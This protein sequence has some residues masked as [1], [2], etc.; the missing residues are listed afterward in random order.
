MPTLSGHREPAPVRVHQKPVQ[1]RPDA[2]IDPY[3]GFELSRLDFPLDDLASLPSYQLALVK[4]HPLASQEQHLRAELYFVKRRVAARD[5]GEEIGLDEAR[6]QLRALERARAVLEQA[7]AE[8]RSRMKDAAVQ[9]GGGKIRASENS[10]HGGRGF[11]DPTD[12][13]AV[14]GPSTTPRYP[15]NLLANPLP[16]KPASTTTPFSP[17]PPQPQPDLAPGGPYFNFDN[18]DVGPFCDP[19]LHAQFHIVRLGQL[20]LHVTPALILAFLCARRPR[21]SFPRPLA[22]RKATHSTG[23]IMLAFRDA[24]AA[25]EV[26][27]RLHGTTLPLTGG[28]KLSTQVIASNGCQFRT[29]SLS[30]E[31][32][33]AWNDKGALPP[34]ARWVGLEPVPGKGVKVSEAYEDEWRAIEEDLAAERERERQARWEQTRQDELEQRRERSESMQTHCSDCGRD[35]Q[36]PNGDGYDCNACQEGWFL[37]HL[38]TKRAR[39]Y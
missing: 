1:P 12:A 36:H 16:S 6:A 11:L 7:R 27:Q 23:A 30:F 17:P 19:A 29:G 32:C 4:Y 37:A 10:G 3:P 38:P 9:I 39:Y 33:A 24:A 5:R 31:V 14:A 21:D 15:V 26:A 13:G 22:I 35:E 34:G 25:A 2:L 18:L 28:A 8:G 20:P